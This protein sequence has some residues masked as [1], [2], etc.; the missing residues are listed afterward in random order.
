MFM[1]GFRFRSVCT[2]I[3]AMQY[4]NILNSISCDKGGNSEPYQS[5]A[6]CAISSSQI[7]IIVNREGVAEA[8]KT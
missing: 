7:T 5:R 1:V 3:D 8:A 2:G 4:L 6:T